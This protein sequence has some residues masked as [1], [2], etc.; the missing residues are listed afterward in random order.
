MV[1]KWGVTVRKLRTKC[2][3]VGDYEDWLANATRL[4]LKP[5]AYVYEFG[6]DDV[7]HLHGIFAREKMLFWNRLRGAPYMYHVKADRLQ[8]V[9]DYDRYFKYMHKN[10]CS[11]DYVLHHSQEV[12]WRNQS[13]AFLPDKVCR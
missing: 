13:Y 4:G 7:L 1:L 9:K 8:S 10:Y 11:R 3:T 2:P 5:L 6:R 12:W